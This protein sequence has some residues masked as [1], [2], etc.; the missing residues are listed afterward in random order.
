MYQ[1]TSDGRNT[2]FTLERPFYSLDTP[3]AMGLQ[4]S[5]LTQ[6]DEIR[7][8]DEVVNSFGHT[9]VDNELYFGIATDINPSFTQRWVVGIA[10]EEDS[11]FSTVDTLQPIPERDKAVYPWIEYQYLQ[12]QYG[13]FKNLNQIQRPEDIST[14]HTVKA[15]IG[16]AG[17]A[18]GN[19]NDV[20]FAK[21]PMA[22][23]CVV[24]KW[25]NTKPKFMAN[26]A[27]SEWSLS[28]SYIQVPGVGS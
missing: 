1:D 6:I 20:R 8:R 2:L 19:A 5:D 26:L 13:V 17:T 23:S 3:R 10:H 27:S 24:G 4:Y 9:A 15:R 14:G 12:N 22:A 11:F 16:F 21:N 28:H 25:R 7:S 18:F